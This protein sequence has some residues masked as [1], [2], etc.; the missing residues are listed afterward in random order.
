MKTETT[1][2][3]VLLFLLIPFISLSQQESQFQGPSRDGI[4]PEAK[5]LKSWPETGPELL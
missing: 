3:I 5:L 4:Y 2:L 1:F